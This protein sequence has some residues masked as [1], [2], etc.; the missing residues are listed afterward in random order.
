MLVFLIGLRF[1]TPS[2]ANA[3]MVQHTI[4]LIPQL[5][6]PALVTAVL[7]QDNDRGASRSSSS[8]ASAYKSKVASLQSQLVGA[9]QNVAVLKSNV[10]AAESKVAQSQAD[11]SY[12]THQRRIYERLELE[13]STRADE[14]TLW[15]DKTEAATR[16]AEAQSPRGQAQLQVADRRRQHQRR[17]RRCPT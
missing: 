13:N 3:T 2:S 10:E 5:T 7:V 1:V 14:V 12:A 4:Q 6:G 11:L 16:E 17:Q 8:I 15:Q 9:T